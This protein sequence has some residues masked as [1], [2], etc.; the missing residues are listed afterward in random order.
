MPFN[1]FKAL[2]NG[3]FISLPRPIKK[4]ICTV[5]RFAN[6]MQLFLHQHAIW[7]PSVS[8]D[9]L[10]SLIHHTLG[11]DARDGTGMAGWLASMKEKD[12]PK[13]VENI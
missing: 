9:W 1:C 3:H 11:H 8:N 5:A 2:G 4:R 13:T 10:I 6:S 7:L 12:K